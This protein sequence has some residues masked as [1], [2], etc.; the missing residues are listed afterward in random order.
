[1]FAYAL[2]LSQLHCGRVQHAGKTPESFQEFLGKRPHIPSWDSVGEEQFQYFRISQTGPFF[3]EE[4]I[5]EAFPMACVV[6]GRLPVGTVCGVFHRIFPEE[7]L[8]AGAVSFQAAYHGPYTETPI[9]DLRDRG[10]PRSTARRRTGSE[11]STGR[12]AR[13]DP[14]VYG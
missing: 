5:L 2:D 14:R 11:V 9:I 4:S 10:V 8:R 3:P 13:G 6:V 1:M 12:W 7:V